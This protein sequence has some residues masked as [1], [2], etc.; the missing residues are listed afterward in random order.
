M[1]G[2]G[3]AINGY[4]DYPTHEIFGIPEQKPQARF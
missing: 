1:V 2:L 3:T 4:V